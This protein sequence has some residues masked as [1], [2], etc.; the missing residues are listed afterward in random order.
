MWLCST[1]HLGDCFLSPKEELFCLRK[2]P[3]VDIDFSCICASQ[4]TERNRFP[5]SIW[6]QAVSKDQ[7]QGS[8]EIGFPVQSKELSVYLK[9]YN[10][11]FPAGQINKP[12]GV[13]LRYFKNHY[14]TQ[15]Q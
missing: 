13:S 4:L 3:A 1:F 11:F 5:R 12:V 7:L 6:E 9:Q 10:I 15:A 8:C 2:A 14:R